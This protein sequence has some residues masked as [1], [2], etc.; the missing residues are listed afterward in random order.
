MKR[1]FTAAAIV[2]AAM[3]GDLRAQAVNGFDPQRERASSPPAGAQAPAADFTP[4]FNKNV[5]PLT[6]ED[7]SHVLVVAKEGGDVYGLGWKCLGPKLAVMFSFP[8][9]LR[10]EGFT[11][12]YRFPPA[13]MRSGSW[14]L[15]D[16]DM[17]VSS[18]EEGSLP[19]TRQALASSRVVLRAAEEWGAGRTTATPTFD[20]TGLKDAI[21]QLP[22]AAKVIQ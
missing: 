18:E 19:F 15:I 10:D 11:V 7:N 13:P 16:H 1:L 22:C 9:Y 2:A 20:L 12:E 14:L 6:D 4:T 8:L 21:R 17:A 3:V 5:D